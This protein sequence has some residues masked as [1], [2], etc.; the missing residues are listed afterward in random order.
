MLRV[1]SNMMNSQLLLNLNRNARTMNDTQLQLSTGRKINKPSDDPVGITYSLRYRAEISSNEQYTKNVD[2]SLSWLDYNDTVLGQAGEVV[3][4][5]RE[6]TVQAATGSNP[7]SALDSIN[8]EVMQLKEQLVDIA[9]SKL[10]GKYI[11]NGE[12]YDVKPYDFV[13]GADG[14]FDTTKAVTT[15]PGQIQY[16][17]GEGVQLPI[18]LSGNDVFGYS[19][20]ADNIFT[21]I[22]NISSALKS[23]NITGVSDQLA[24]VDTRIE[25]FLTARS[26]IGAKTNRVELMQERLSDL[27]TNLTELQAKTEDASYEELIMNSKIQENIYNASL[28]VGAK[29]I[30]TTLVDFIR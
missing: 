23:G 19:S 1:T 25:K 10:N 24:N 16:V 14:T 20:D 12:Q 22:N 27:N 6:L 7:Q 15:D 28:S 17:V 2:S 5:L 9:N 18:S 3:Q 8:E 11:F 26:E 21:V 30:S 4:R 29:I 13:K